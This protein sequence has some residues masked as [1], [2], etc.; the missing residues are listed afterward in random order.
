VTVGVGTSD[1]VV[2]NLYA[3]HRGLH[4]RPHLDVCG[5]RV[6]DNVRD[7]IGG[8]ATEGCDARVGLGL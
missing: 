8:G 6:L 3:E 5:V 1:A 7:E 2:A 4:R